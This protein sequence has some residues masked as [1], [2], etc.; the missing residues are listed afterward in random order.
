MKKTVL[1]ATIVFAVAAMAS[2]AFAQQPDWLKGTLK[3]PLNN[4]TLGFSTVG[5]GLNGYTA[6]FAKTFDQLAAQYHVKVVTLDAQVDPARQAQE[7]PSFV[8]EHVDVAIVW[9]VN[10]M[11]ILPSLRLLNRAQIPILNVNT[12]VAPAGQKYITAFTGPNDYH[13]A[14]VAGKLMVDALGGMGNVVILTGLPGYSVTKYR[15]DG[16]LDAIKDTPGIKVLDTQPADW[17]QEKAQ[18]LMENFITRFGKKIDGVYSSDGGTGSGALAAGL[19]AVSEGRLE[20]GHLKYTDCSIF[21][22]TYDSI[23]AGDYYG[24]VYQSPVNDADLA[25]KTAVEIAEGI[26]VPKVSHIPAPPVTKANV[27]QYPRPTF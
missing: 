14:Q 11:A 18:T 26:A 2:S 8:T 27:D 20:K 19:A 24:S 3:K 4:I 13:E 1:A 17:S 21:A 25:F 7:I 9:P 5:V 23:K 22:S 15:I 12:Q 10:S 6:T 16:F